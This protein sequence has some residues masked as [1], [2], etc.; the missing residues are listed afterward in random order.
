MDDI[1]TVILFLSITFP[2]FQASD[3][4]SLENT[5]LLHRYLLYLVAYSQ[6][7]CDHFIKGFVDEDFNADL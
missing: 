7:I 5:K 1:M 6:E 4:A 2:V 3:I